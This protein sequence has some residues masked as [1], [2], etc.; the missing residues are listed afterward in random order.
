[1]S[2]WTTVTY[3]EDISVILSWE[4]SICI[5]RDEATEA[6]FWTAKVAIFVGVVAGCPRWLN[7]SS[8]LRQNC[9][10]QEEV[11]YPVTVCFLLLGHGQF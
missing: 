9:S 1:M 5:R 11:M 8:Q 3:I 7:D 2:P 10:I 6:R 4:F